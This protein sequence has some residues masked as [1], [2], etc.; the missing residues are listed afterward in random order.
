MEGD[1]PEA[2]IK[3]WIEQRLNATVRSM[4]RQ[5]RWRPAWFV[6][7]ET[8]QG[9]LPLYVLLPAKRVVLEMPIPYNFLAAMQAP[10]STK[11]RASCAPGMKRRLFFNPV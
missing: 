2:K 5:A 1:T 3:R 11:F 6:E 8:E 9:A 4:E 7:A 10:A